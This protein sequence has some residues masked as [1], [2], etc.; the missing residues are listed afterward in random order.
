[1]WFSRATRALRQLT[2]TFSSDACSTVLRARPFSH[3]LE[4]KLLRPL[5]LAQHVLTVPQSCAF[6]AGRRCYTMIR[7]A[8]TA[9]CNFSMTQAIFGPGRCLRRRLCRAGGISFLS[10]GKV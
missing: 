10:S 2:G 7:R 3:Y 8:G 5:G 4:T 1:M 9:P 6:L